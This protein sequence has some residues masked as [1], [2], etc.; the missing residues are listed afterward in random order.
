MPQLLE[1]A[2]LVEQHGV[3]E[4]QIRCG[5][6]ETGFHPQRHAG[7]QARFELLKL[8]DLLGTAA[9]ERKGFIDSGQPQ[10]PAAF[11]VNNMN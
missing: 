7:G 10:T 1:L 8:E 2:H 9:N 4:M 3:A 11:A 5:G 6:I